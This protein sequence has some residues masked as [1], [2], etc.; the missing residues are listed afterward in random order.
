MLPL[1]NF[2]NIESPE[3]SQKYTHR[4]PVTAQVTLEK[5]GLVNPTWRCI[6]C[7]VAR[8]AGLT[9]SY[10]YLDTVHVTPYSI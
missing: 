2:V 8:L 10:P 6:M 3:A 7:Q 4:L 9:K 5:E 1:D